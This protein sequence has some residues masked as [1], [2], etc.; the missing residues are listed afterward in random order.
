MGQLWVVCG[1]T[2]LICVLQ[3]WKGVQRQGDGGKH[4]EEDG[5]D[6]QD[7]KDTFIK[8]ILVRSAG[9]GNDIYQ[10][11]SDIRYKVKHKF[12][13]LIRLIPEIV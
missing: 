3:L 2:K 8:V 11:K 5:D 12:L 7:L 10:L 9:S 13:F 4:D 6:G 1:L